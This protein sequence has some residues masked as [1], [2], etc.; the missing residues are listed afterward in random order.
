[1]NERMMNFEPRS[2]P[3]TASWGGW[4]DENGNQCRGGE[5]SV[6]GLNEMIPAV[7]YSSRCVLGLVTRA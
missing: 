1:M 5:P 3:S 7:G 4:T 6:S 2:K